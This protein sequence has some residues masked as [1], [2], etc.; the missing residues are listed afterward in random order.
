MPSQ[1][2]IYTGT[3]QIVQAAARMRHITCLSEG[4]KRCML[5]PV[6]YGKVQG[7]A[8]EKD[9]NPAVFLSQAT[10]AFRK[11]THTNPE[12]TEGRTPLAMHS[13]TQPMP[14]TWRELQKLEAGPQALLSTLA[15][16]AESA[17]TG[18]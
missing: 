9:E 15:E 13:I 2:M 7:V 12:S 6:D 8:Q 4:M 14:D 1:S 18:T 17:P 16:E 5:K 11:D 3:M 10:K